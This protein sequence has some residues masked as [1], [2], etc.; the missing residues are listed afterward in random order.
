VATNEIHRWQNDCTSICC[1]TH[2]YSA[3]TLTAA[4]LRI[5]DDF[6]NEIQ[7]FSRTQPLFEDLPGLWNDTKKFQDFHGFFKATWEHCITQK[8]IYKC[9]ILA[10]SPV[11]VSSTSSITQHG[12]FSSPA[13]AAQILHI[14]CQYHSL[15]TAE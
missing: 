5:F 3:D 1:F 7:G 10:S 15:A 12:S 6:P 13:N 4:D 14:V 8:H 9:S 2:S 11:M